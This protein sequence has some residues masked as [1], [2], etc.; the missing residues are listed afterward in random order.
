MVVSKDPFIKKLFPEAAAPTQ[1]VNTKKLA[2]VSVGSKFKVS[3]YGLVEGHDPMLTYRL[4]SLQKFSIF[5]APLN[6]TN[7]H[8]LD[9]TP[10]ESITYSG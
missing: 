1:G 5:H 9:I 8:H 7:F 2:L 6:F 3:M 10:P 4:F